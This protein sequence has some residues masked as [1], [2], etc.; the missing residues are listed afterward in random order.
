[1]HV[2]LLLQPHDE[3]ILAEHGAE[4]NYVHC[5]ARSESLNTPRKHK[6]KHQRANSPHTKHQI[7]LR[8]INIHVCFDLLL[9]RWLWVATERVTECNRSA[10]KYDHDLQLALLVIDELCLSIVHINA[11]LVHFF[12]VQVAIF[13]AA[14]AGELVEALLL[15]ITVLGP[16]PLFIHIVLSSTQFFFQEIKVLKLIVCEKSVYVNTH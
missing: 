9:E 13:V 6:R 14:V 15:V 16:L 8:V 3:N 4:N 2:I 1:M 10:Q 11:L 12:L 7:K 5:V